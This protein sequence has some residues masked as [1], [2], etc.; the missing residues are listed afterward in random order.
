M[1][2]RVSAADVGFLHRETR[3]S[4]QHTGG[5]VVLDAGALDYDRLVRLLE[6]RISLAPRYRQKVRTVPGHLASPVWV[7]DPRFDITYHVRRSALPR[8]GTEA[9]LL[10]FCA[11]IH[12]RL[13][14]RARPLWEMYLIEGLAGGRVAILTKTHAAMVGEQGDIDLAQVI[15]DASPAPRLT[16]EPVWMPEPEPRAAELVLDAALG[17][18]RSPWAVTDTARTAARDAGALARRMSSVAGGLA[19]NA[20][21]VLRRPSDSPLHVTLGE[22]RRLAVAR[23][24]FAD[25]RQVRDAFGGTVNDVALAV[26]TGALRGWLL[27]RAVGL[28]PAATVR[29]L[30]PVAVA[31]LA[32][33]PPP[34]TPARRRHTGTRASRSTVR[35]LLVDLPVGE[36]DPVLRLAQLRYAMAS[37]KATGRAVSADELAELAGFAPPTMHLLGVRAAS[38]LTR[39]LFSLV[40][41]NVPGPQVPLYAAG[42]RMSEMFPFLP[43]APGQALSVALTS[44]DGGVYFGI[45]ADYDAV[46]DAASFAELIEASLAELV[47]TLGPDGARGSP[48]A[49]RGVRR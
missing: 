45:N 44:Y 37:H 13:L 46:P 2:E 12:S 9:Q 21:A 1:P 43:L 22:Q 10:E 29:A 49:M 24:Q 17:L 39:R 40:I 25:Y 32:A 31:D 14:D 42:A 36:P 20:G 38:E 26:V 47:A 8:P 7:D 34:G 23:T 16:V 27:S 19:A 15:L 18:V 41:T 3:T 28:R 35:P 30:V 6:E 33:A 5:I 11:R 4:P 48:R